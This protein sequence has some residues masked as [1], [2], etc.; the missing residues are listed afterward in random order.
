MC[1]LSLCYQVVITIQYIY[2]YNTVLDGTAWYEQDG[3]G[4]AAAGYSGRYYTSCLRCCPNEATGLDLCTETISTNE[5]GSRCGTVGN[6]LF[7]W[8]HQYHPLYGYFG[9]IAPCCAGEVCLDNTAGLCG[10]LC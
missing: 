6:E 1:M 7:F 3:F 5:P 2:I 10:G 9:N 4:G 8:S